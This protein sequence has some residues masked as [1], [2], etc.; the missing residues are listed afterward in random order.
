M[1]RK[2]TGTYQ[3]YTSVKR[4]QRSYSSDFVIKTGALRGNYRRI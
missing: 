4:A 2:Q 3:E 1:R